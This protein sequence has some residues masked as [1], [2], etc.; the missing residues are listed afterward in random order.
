MDINLRDR[1]AKIIAPH[2]GSKHK[3]TVSLEIADKVIK[4]IESDFQ[5][6]LS[7]DIK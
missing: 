2:L 4:E 5:D 7:W 6:K 1:I 3:N